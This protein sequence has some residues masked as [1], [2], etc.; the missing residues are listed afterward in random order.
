[1]VL[2]QHAETAR[3]T[4]RIV[5][6]PNVFGRWGRPDYNSAIATFCHRLNRGIPIEV[7]E[8]D[9]VLRLVHV[10]DVADCFEREMTARMTGSGWFE[11]GPVY[12]I[13]LG[14]VAA[15]LQGFAQGAAPDD[16]TEEPVD[17][18]LLEKLRRTYDAYRVT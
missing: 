13:R 2:W 4:V 5:R 6:L 8:P 7:H 11:V 17:P 15:V 18:E 3:S 12:G 1:A 16:L 9:R 14:T 10:D